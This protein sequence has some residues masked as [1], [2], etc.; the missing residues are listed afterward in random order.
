M[1]IHYLCFTLNKSYYHVILYT[2]IVYKYTCSKTPFLRVYIN[3]NKSNNNKTKPT[4]VSFIIDLNINDL[5]I[6]LIT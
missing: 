1:L 6:E 2:L 4:D 3:D 5:N